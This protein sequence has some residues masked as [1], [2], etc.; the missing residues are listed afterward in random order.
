MTT[1]VGCEPSVQ[2]AFKA[3]GDPTRRQILMS[4]SRQNMSIA[5]IVDEFPITR[6]AIKKHLSVLEEGRLIRVEI[7]GRERINKLEP[8]GMQSALGWLQYFDS[9]WDNKL[10]N[11]KQIIERAEER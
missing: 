6:S 5:E 8:E 7:R 10:G 3:L 4:L 2:L 9:F 11:L 1:G